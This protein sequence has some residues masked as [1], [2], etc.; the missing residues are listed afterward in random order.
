M[1]TQ[2][3]VARKY[4]QIPHFLTSPVQLVPKRRKIS[5]DQALQMVLSTLTSEYRQRPNLKCF[6]QILAVLML[7][8]K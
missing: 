3:A 5:S 2:Y 7:L 6:F 1:Q 8:W 4:V